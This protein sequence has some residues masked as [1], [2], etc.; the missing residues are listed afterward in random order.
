MSHRTTRSRRYLIA[1]AL[2]TLGLTASAQQQNSSD[3]SLAPTYHAEQ[4]ARRPLMYL[5]DQSGA[6]GRLDQ[7]GINIYGHIE[8]GWTHNFDDPS[9]GQNAFRSFDFE[10]DEHTLNQIDLTIARV[11]DYRQQKW[12]VGFL[13]E[14]M[15]GGDAGLIHANGIFDWYDGVR[16]PENQ[17]DPVQFYVDVTMPFLNGSRLRMGKFANLVGFESINPTQDF[18]GFY[19]RSFV[20]GT[21]YP[22]THLG[23]L[24]TF[25]IDAARRWTLTA[26]ITR[27]DEQG[28]EDNNDVPAFLGSLNWQ[29]NDRMSLYIANST[30]P[31]QPGN[32]SDIR[33]TWDATFYWKPTDKCRFLAN[34]YFIY[35]AA[36]DPVG[37]SGV[38]YAFA[39]LGSYD[40]CKEA[41]FKVR[42]EWFHDSDGLRT[43]ENLDLFEV[44]AGLDIIPF[45]RRGHALLGENLII[46]P[47]LRWDFADEDV[48][49]GSDNQ[50]TFGI[51]VIFKI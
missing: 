36:G 17:F 30:G 6:A 24:Y 41:R 27:G 39:A 2:A 13:M 21:G 28:F 40:F 43:L 4:T 18:I 48:F 45:A 34:V 51:D 22:F 10:H 46:R 49:D 37:D 12:D 20:F 32:D 8:L 5:L 1:A 44:T 26:G 3:L 9:T 38:L 35:D 25:D 47:E 16:D 7:Y 19:S 33:T 14:W 42:A 23:A 50:F 29:I 15:Y 11:V 31:E